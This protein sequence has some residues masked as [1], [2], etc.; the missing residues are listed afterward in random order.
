[1][2]L[3]RALKSE[4]S[5][6]GKV[7][8]NE[9]IVKFWNSR[10]LEG[11]EITES[12]FLKKYEQNLRQICQSLKSVPHPNILKD[13]MYNTSNLIQK[14]DGLVKRLASTLIKVG[15]NVNR[16]RESAWD[17]WKEKVNAGVKIWL[18]GMFENEVNVITSIA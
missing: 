12:L 2:G 3:K 4:L 15:Y 10:I 6:K 5:K 17:D 1:M 16:I 7:I 8:T 18:K 13:S 9:N 11:I 14:W